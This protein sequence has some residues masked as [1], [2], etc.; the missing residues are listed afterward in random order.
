MSR[1]PMCLQE[2][3]VAFSKEDVIMSG[4]RVFARRLVKMYAMKSL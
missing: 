3:S 4:E 2:D 1:I